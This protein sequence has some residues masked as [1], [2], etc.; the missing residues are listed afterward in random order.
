MK[1]VEV[2]VTTALWGL[3]GLRTGRAYV[4]GDVIEA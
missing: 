2:V 4:A 3:V 1:R